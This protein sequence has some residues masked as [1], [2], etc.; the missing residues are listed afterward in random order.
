MNLKTLKQ[1]IIEIYSK[2]EILENVRITYISAILG[3]RGKFPKKG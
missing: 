2:I 1:T 3:G